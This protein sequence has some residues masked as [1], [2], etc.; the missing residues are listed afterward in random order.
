MLSDLI[1]ML[2]EWLRRSGRASLGRRV[3]VTG[4]EG[5]GRGVKPPGQR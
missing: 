5:S 1:V 2:I 4:M 3:E